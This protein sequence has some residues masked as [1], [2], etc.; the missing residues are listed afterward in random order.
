MRLHPK[1]NDRNVGLRDFIFVSCVTILGL[2]PFAPA[3]AKAHFVSVGTAHQTFLT[4]IN[5]AGEVVG[6]DDDS[7]FVRE[8]DGTMTSFGVAG[9]RSTWTSGIND[10]GDIAGYAFSVASGISFLRD[11]SGPLTTFSA[12]GY[13]FT[14]AM[15]L[16]A[17]RVVAGNVENS[18]GVPHGFVRQPDGAFL[19]FDPAGSVGTQPNSINAA[20]TV[21]GI[22]YLDSGAQLIAHGFMRTADGTLTVID[23]P[24]SSQTYARSIN[25]TGW[26][27]GSYYDSSKVSHGFVRSPEGTITTFGSAPDSLEVS[28][29]NDGGVVTGVKKSSGFIRRVNGTIS[30]F[31]MIRMNGKKSRFTTPA[32]INDSG[33]IVGTYW[34][35]IAGQSYQAGFIRF[36]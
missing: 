8:P 35:S 25:G 19:I 21:V 18:D 28:S 32:A 2:A 17:S 1:S 4:G 5:A 20:G 9:Q 27:A 14:N 23:V 7:A 33:V 29:M 15:C 24:D 16:N 11:P 26:I 34:S 31:R 3:E 22:F 30:I 6:F 13:A 10:N 36:P 12:P